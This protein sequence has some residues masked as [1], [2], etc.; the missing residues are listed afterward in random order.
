V[1][2]ESPGSSLAE[3][4]ENQV[5]S[6][7]DEVRALDPAGEARSQTFQPQAARRGRNSRKTIRLFGEKNQGFRF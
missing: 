2:C 6:P 3:G 5:R 7:E 1:E 4:N